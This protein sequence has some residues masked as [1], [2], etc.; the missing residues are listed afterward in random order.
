MSRFPSA[1]DAKRL[2]NRNGGRLGDHLPVCWEDLHCAWNES[3]SKDFITSF[4]AQYPHYDDQSEEILDHFWQ[5]LDRLKSLRHRT[6]RREGETQVQCDSRRHKMFS[7]EQRR[8]RKRSRQDQAGPSFSSEACRLIFL[9]IQLHLDRLRVASENANHH[10]NL[11]QRR[12]WASVLC[13]I[14]KLGVPGMSSDESEDT[15]GNTPER[16]YTIKARVWR[17]KEIQDLMVR[18]D[19]ELKQTKR[20]LYGNAPPGNPPRVR[21]R[22]KTPAHSQRAAVA[23]LPVNFYNR[24]WLRKLSD[25]ARGQLS[26]AHHFQLPKLSPFSR[27]S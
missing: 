7:D 9:P 19:Q 27:R 16:R 20:S 23:R 6:S 13:I 5:R 26:S 25:I 22:V 14:E 8:L 21:H 3:L 11:E 17:S 18:T 15:D 10:P 2:T 12:H 1:K 4:V 24:D